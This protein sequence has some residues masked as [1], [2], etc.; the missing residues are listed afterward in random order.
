MRYLL[1]SLVHIMLY[2]C[3]LVRI[4]SCSVYECRVLHSEYSMNVGRL[5]SKYSV[6]VGSL[7]RNHS[8]N[9]NVGPL[10]RKY[11]AQW[12]KGVQAVVCRAACKGVQGVENN[13]NVYMNV[14]IS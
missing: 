4:I 11:L 10:D 5:H 6:N 7:H 9:L 12:C 2:F 13:L 3:L 1:Y 14:I 8:V